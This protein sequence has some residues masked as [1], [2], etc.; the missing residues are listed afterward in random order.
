MAI[1][2]S[3]FDPER[4]CLCPMCDMPIFDYDESSVIVSDDCK[5]LAHSDC[6]RQYLAE[7]EEDGE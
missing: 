6:V 1:E 3:N 2:L 4:I 7:N 5:C